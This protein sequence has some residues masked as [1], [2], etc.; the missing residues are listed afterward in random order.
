M[1]KVRLVLIGAGNRG[2]AY[3]DL[4]AEFCPEME[5]IAVADP[6]PVRRNYIR[7]KFQLSEDCCF[8]TGEELLK[9]PKMADAAIIATQ[10]QKHYALAMEAIKVG[11][12]LL[13]EKPAAP[14]PEECLAIADA[15]NA[16]NLTVVV[17]HV[18]RFTPFFRL[19]KNLID[20]GRVGKVLNIAHI[21]CVGNVH[22]SHSYVRGNWHKTADSTPMILAKSCHDLDI[23]QWLLNSR[24]TRVQS[25][26]SLQYFRRENMPE[27][28]PEYCYQG[29]P[30][31]ADCPYSAL[32]IYRDRQFPS[33]VRTATKKHE[34]T[35]EDIEYA[36]TQTNYGRCVFQCD[37]DVVD[38]QVVNLEYES[39]ATVSFN[40]SAFNSGGRKIR[41][42]GTKGELYGEMSQ[43]F[44]TLFDFNT[45]TLT[46][47]NIAE[48]V[49]D[50]SIQGGHGGGDRG[51]IR[52]F[53]QLM[54]G[55]YKGNSVTDISTSIENHLVAFAAE[56]SRLNGNVVAM[57][58]YQNNIYQQIK[59]SLQ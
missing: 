47:I 40:M 11:Y 37:N 50:E 32:K 39:G 7:D 2:T 49:L 53:C 14:T 45:R 35:D 27:G 28:A 9:Q 29:C 26:G 51:I 55:E 58:D 25:F 19:I 24:C 13:L 5:L 15:A 54:C 12:H 10:D 34:P 42:M 31:E 57:K 21:E 59:A 20:E 56:E 1:K 36:I 6:D 30:A 44:V 16:K 22:Q 3:T 33:F 23:V 4:G 18:L 41:V 43:D 38:H 8:E 52:A 48:A 46:K 17:C